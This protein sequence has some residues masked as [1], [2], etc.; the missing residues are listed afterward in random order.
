MLRLLRR[1]PRTF[2]IQIQ[3]LVLHISAGTDFNEEDW[4]GHDRRWLEVCDAVLL[5]DGYSTGAEQ[6]VKRACEL[7]KPIF[8]EH[9]PEALIAWAKEG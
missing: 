7:G 8:H 9:N 5:L 6:E 2:D 4:M 1:K 3:D